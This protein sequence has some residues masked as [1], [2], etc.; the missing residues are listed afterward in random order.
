MDP[1]L[2]FDLISNDWQTRRKT[3]SQGLE[4]SLQY[5]TDSETSHLIDLI[6]TYFRPKASIRTVNAEFPLPTRLFK[7]WKNGVRLWPFV[8][9]MFFIVNNNKT[10]LRP[11]FNY[12][13]MTKHFKTPHFNLPSL[14]Q[15]L[16]SITGSLICIML[17]W[18]FPKP[19][20][21]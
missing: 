9:S 6:P 15:L 18:I 17:S 3:R 12:G 5:R 10:S 14:Y 2:E 21:I 1:L 4:G 16:K 7:L 20:S 19:F 11:I 8:S 13:H